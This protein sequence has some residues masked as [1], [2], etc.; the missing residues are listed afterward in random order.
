MKVFRKRKETARQA[1]NEKRRR[2]GDPFAH[3]LE[4]LFKHREEARV[5]SLFEDEPA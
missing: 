2:D 1:M 3:L 4:S 5:L